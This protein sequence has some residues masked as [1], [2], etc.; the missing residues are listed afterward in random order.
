MALDPQVRDGFGLPVVRLS[1]TTHLET[2]RTAEFMRQRAE[3]W[4]RASGAERVWSWPPEK[5]FSAGQHQAGTCRMSADPRDGVVDASCRSDA[6]SAAVEARRADLARRRL[7]TAASAQMVHRC[8][9]IVMEGEGFSEVGNQRFAWAKNDVF[10]I[11]N[12]LWRRH[13]NRGPKDAMLYL[14]SDRALFE[15]IGQYRAQGRTPD[16]DVVQLAT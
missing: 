13:I 8:V 6:V 12:F 4:L 5:K 10:V 15:K 16:G 2:V 14:C 9:V 7:A 3:E 1:G 11:P